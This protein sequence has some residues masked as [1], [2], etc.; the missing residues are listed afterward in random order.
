MR[1][2]S[3]NLSPERR[4]LLALR[5]Q[6]K[7]IN[8]PETQAILPRKTGDPCPLSFAQQRLWFLDQLEPGSTAY[9]IPQAF[10]FQG[11][12]HIEALERSLEELVRRHEILRTTFAVRTGLGADPQPVQVVHPASDGVLPV[13]D[14]RGLRETQRSELAQWLA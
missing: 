11:E 7:G 10:S 4:K 3:G 14:L 5:R 2:F 13:I 6:Q 9:L 8:I 12:L 1:K